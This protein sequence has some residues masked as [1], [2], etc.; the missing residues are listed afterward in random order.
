MAVVRTG[1]VTPSFAASNLIILLYAGE[2]NLPM[3]KGLEVSALVAMLYY[4]MCLVLVSGSS[5]WSLSQYKQPLSL[6]LNVDRDI[7]TEP[8]HA[9]F[10]HLGA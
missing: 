7:L 6:D 8:R 1:V 2:Y 4:S 3:P 5:S 10:G 9:D